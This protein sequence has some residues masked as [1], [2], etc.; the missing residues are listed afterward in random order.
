MAK[1]A[2]YGFNKSHSAAYALIAYQTAYLKAH[3]PVEFMAA[4]LSSEMGNPDK[5]LRYLSE[6]RDKRI[7]VLPPDVNESQQDF[8]VVGGKIRFGLAAVKNVGQAATQSILSAR[9]EKENFGSLPDFCLK[10]DLRKVNKRVI[11]SLIKCGAFDSIGPSRAQL[12]AGLEEAMEWSQGLERERSNPQI[13]LFGGSQSGRGKAEPRLPVVP[14]WPESQ[15]LAFEK[16]TLGFYLTGHPLTRY[17][18][19]LQRLTTT[20]TQ[21]IR[22]IAD[23]QEIVIGGVVNTLK[24]ITT[25]KGDRMAFVTLEDLNGVVEV[26]IFAELYKNSYIAAEG[27][28]THFHQGEGRCGGR[29][30]QNH[31]Q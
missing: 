14:E 9:E 2:E 27:R 12:L 20:N 31:R 4:L 19:A 8:T 1:F 18:E 5:I 17:A 13:I 16:E 24:E 3:Y 26:I 21:Q 10:V 28:R 30:C 22:E 15:R 25:K 6:C 7:E 11:E 23:G 29:E